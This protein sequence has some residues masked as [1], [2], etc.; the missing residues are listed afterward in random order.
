MV[1]GHS[2]TVDDIVNSLLGKKVLN[3]LHDT[4]YGDLF[5]VKKKGKSLDYE[6]RRFE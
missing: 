2:N 6:A 1:V 3:D 5:M 4:Q